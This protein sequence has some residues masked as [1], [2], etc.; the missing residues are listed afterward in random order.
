MI[1]P[2]YII[3][4]F[5]LLGVGLVSC[6]KEKSDPIEIKDISEYNAANFYINTSEYYLNPS[7]YTG[8]S[9]NNSNVDIDKDIVYHTNFVTNNNVYIGSSAYFTIT[10]DLEFH[11]DPATNKIIPHTIGDSFSSD[12]NWSSTPNTGLYSSNN[13]DWNDANPTFKHLIFRKNINGEYRYGW[14]IARVNGVGPSV[15]QR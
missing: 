6:K 12:M 10:S 15:M 3:C 2:L 5:A 4:L 7:D 11:V 13:P 8:Y 1:K 9:F 14:V